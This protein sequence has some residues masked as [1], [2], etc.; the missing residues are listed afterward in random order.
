ML[1]IIVFLTLYFY[2]W[3]SF[4]ESLYNTFLFIFLMNVYH[5]AYWIYT[6]L[7]RKR[8]NFMDLY[9]KN[10]WALV[11]CA[12]NP[13]GKELCKQI[14]LSGFNM[15][16]VGT[17]F[18]EVSHLSQDLRALSPNMEVKRVVYDFNSQMTSKEYLDVFKEFECIDISLIVNNTDKPEVKN[19][20]DTAMEDLEEII[21]LNIRPQILITKIFIQNLIKRK[22]S[23]VINISSGLSIIPNKMQA[24]YAAT[25]KTQDYLSRALYEEYSGKID[26]LTVRPFNVHNEGEKPKM[27]SVSTAVF[28]RNIM[29]SLGYDKVTYGHWKHQVLGY[30]AELLPRSIAQRFLF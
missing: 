17:D 5:L 1:K 7:R 28:A 24:M 4:S 22:R 10:S 29:N 26:F 2:Y 9:G 20:A 3:K 18:E 13:I 16:L 6:I 19:F 12:T 14:A 23:A 25:K 8:K 21:N 11:T 30:L 15:I 27:F